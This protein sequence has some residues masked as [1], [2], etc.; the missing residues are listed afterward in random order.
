VTVEVSFMTNDGV[1]KKA[2]RNVDPEAF[3]KTALVIHED[4][5]AK[6]PGGR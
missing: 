6:R 2:V 3:S 4:E 1:R 5:A